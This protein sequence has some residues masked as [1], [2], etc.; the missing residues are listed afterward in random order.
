MYMYEYIIYFIYP[1]MYGPNS[2]NVISLHLQSVV[3]IILFNFIYQQKVN[4][5]YLLFPEKY[6]IS[7][8]L[9]WTTS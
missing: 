3:T 1:V 9:G 5:F 6:L 7:A 4:L 2:K 8:D